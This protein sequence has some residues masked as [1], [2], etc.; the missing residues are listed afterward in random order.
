MPKSVEN[1]NHP[2]QRHD[3]GQGDVLDLVHTVMHL[4]RAQQFRTLRDG[5]GL[6]HMESKVL[7]FFAR[8]PGATLSELV[9]HAG[10]DKGQ[11]ARLVAGLRERGLLQ[12]EP[13]PRDARS[14]RLQLTTEGEAAAQAIRRQAR[15]VSSAATQGLTADERA[16]LVALL[17]KV[18]S[19]L[20]AAQAT[21]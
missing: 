3:D 18:R 17:E 1:I 10:R 12:A 13:D 20:E 4:Y 21:E 16:H 6:T 7:G 5:E 14:V 11:L 15:K 2:R 8:Q 19:N 9:A